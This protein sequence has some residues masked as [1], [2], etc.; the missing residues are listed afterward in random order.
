MP[1]LN[2][3][4][5]RHPVDV[6]TPN[7]QLFAHLRWPDQIEIT[8]DP[9]FAER[10]GDQE[11]GEQLSR[12]ARLLFAARAATYEGVKK[13]VLEPNVPH[14]ERPRDIAY[15]EAYEKLAV[16][17]SSNDGSVSVTCVG[18]QFWTVTVA[19]GSADRIGTSGIAQAATEA[20]NKVVAE[21]RQAVRDLRHET[22]KNHD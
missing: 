21:L 8:I 17:A 19:P 14:I 15:R 6:S 3:E 11:T 7:G 16:E 4:L 2:E 18:L 22:Y 9:G 20:A 13:Q 10:R 12:L 1:V 5:Q